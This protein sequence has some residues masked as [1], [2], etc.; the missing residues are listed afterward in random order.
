[1]FDDLF[2]DDTPEF[3]EDNEEVMNSSLFTPSNIGEQYFNNIFGNTNLKNGI[4]IKVYEIDDELNLNKKFPE[5]DV[6]VVEQK[7]NSSVEPVIYKNCIAIDSFGGIADFFEY[8]RRPVEEK[9][10]SDTPVDTNFK[11]QFGNMVLILCL[12]G[13]T[14][15]GIIVNSVPHPGRKTTLTKDADLHLEGEYN[16]LNWQ[17]NKEGELTVTYKSKTNI[18]GEPQDETAGGTTLKMD[19]EGSVDINTNLEGDEE[20]Y[21]RMDKKNKDIGLKAGANVGFTAKKDVAMNAD[22]KITG[23]AKGAVEFTAEGTAKVSAKSS[24]ALEGESAVNI[25]GGNVIISGQNG[26]IIEGQQCMIDTQKVFVGQGGTPAIIATT[27]FQGIG[28]FGAPVIST[29]I[30]PYSGSVFIAS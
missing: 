12:D 26:V 30:G 17:I 23:K 29:A 6:L 2:D 25:K 7:K 1:M 15:K 19:K 21:M 18:K 13:S 11:D 14:D 20:T 16:G 28:N 3:Y 8:K 5:Y 27:K 22:G 10:E 24:L 9:K 4:I